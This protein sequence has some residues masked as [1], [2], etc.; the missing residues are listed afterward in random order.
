MA[1]GSSAS[2]SSSSS[3]KAAA[4]QA[5]ITSYFSKADPMSSAS[6][7]TS[8]PVHLPPARPALVASGSGSG[9]KASTSDD[10]SNA[11]KATGGPP[12]TPS[13]ARKGAVASASGLDSPSKSTPRKSSP[14]K[15]S[16]SA[17]SLSSS[18]GQGSFTKSGT[19]ASAT[20][21]SDSSS[22]MEVTLSPK[23]AP[24]PVK[25]DVKGKGKAL[26]AITLSTTEEDDDEDEDVPDSQD[27]IALHLFPNGARNPPPFAAAKASPKIPAVASAS[28]YSPSCKKAASPKLGSPSRGRSSP[29]KGTITPRA[30]SATP[31]VAAVSSPASTSS[32]RSTR[33]AAAAAKKAITE[34]YEK[35]FGQQGMQEYPQL[36]GPSRA[37]SRQATPRAGTPR[38]TRATSVAVQSTTKLTK[39]ALD[40][41]SPDPS[42]PPRSSRRTTADASSRYLRAPS[43]SPLS[44]LGPTPKKPTASR[45]AVKKASGPHFYFDFVVPTRRRKPVLRRERS[46]TAPE[47]DAEEEDSDEDRMEVDRDDGATEKGSPTKRKQDDIDGS[48]TDSGSS[49][50]SDSADESEDDVL[51]LALARAK[52]RRDDGTALV[53]TSSTAHPSSSTAA[54]PTSPDI[55]RS[56]RAAAKDEERAK[57]K[58]REKQAREKAKM[59]M[60]M[61]L[62]DLEGGARGRLGIAALQRERLERE[63][64]GRSADWLEGKRL[65][66]EAEGYEYDSD[67]S[68]TNEDKALTL[69]ADKLED[70]VSAAANVVGDPDE[71]YAAFAGSPQ[72]RE[73][74]QEALRRANDI[75]TTLKDDVGRATRENSGEAEARKARCFWRDEAKVVVWEDKAGQGEWS[76]KIEKAIGA[77]RKESKLF[78]SSIILFSRLNGQGSPEERSVIAKRLLSLVSHP[79]TAPE[80][81][82]R[83][84]SLI[85]RLVMHTTRNPSS[86]PL[87]NAADFSAELEKLGARTELLD[88]PKEGDKDAAMDESDE[89]DAIVV[90][91]LGLSKAGTKAAKEM[92]REISAE[93]QK[94]GTVRLL[95]VVQGVAGSK[96]ALFNENDVVSLVAVCSRLALDPTAAPMRNAIER[97]LEVLL[98]TTSLSDPS[99]VCKVYEQLITIHH[100]SRAQLQLEL[101]RALPQLSK[102]NKVLRKWLAWGFL[103][104]LASALAPVAT[105]VRRTCF[106]S[107]VLLEISSLTFSMTHRTSSPFL[108]LS[109]RCRPSSKAPAMDRSR[110]C[111]TWTTQG[112][113]TM[114]L[115]SP[116]P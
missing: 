91:E 8:T 29:A 16:T 47:L 48:L 14:L 89:D 24:S 7:R 66:A 75:A 4:R 45:T 11:T 42:T 72:K 43:G 90:Q 80:L 53:P 30:G 28:F 70:L 37:L 115:P 84:H 17:R 95:S 50:S 82:N 31:A 83:A 22:D 85:D 68:S 113:T 107:C 56:S 1:G 104:G 88:L 102:A 2:S 52:A 36:P 51:A 54:L 38:V 13:A 71:E 39:E 93:E 78:P 109:R 63:K 9:K 77:G 18:R 49:S 27:H 46:L 79:L 12:S 26:A 106:R 105:P 55:R 20:R 41:L 94:E 40:S 81:A 61:G 112:S 57:E 32:R 59:K 69:N 96:P 15:Q 58:E 100:D 97:T 65:L 86:S 6:T 44:S 76:S 101:L 114:R 35:S 74:Q 103:A 21:S 92:E 25:Q 3:S 10:A 60:E 98:N 110:S 108:P 33:D 111:P 99:I 73:A 64:T 67:A 62:M 34:S 23:K 5:S 116:S 87:F 19:H